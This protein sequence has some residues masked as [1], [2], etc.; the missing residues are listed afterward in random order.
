MAANPSST[1][2]PGTTPGGITL[3]STQGILGYSRHPCLY[4][5]LP[6]EEPDTTEYRSRYALVIIFTTPRLPTGSLH[7]CLNHT[8]LATH[9]PLPPLSAADYAQRARWASAQDTPPL[10]L[11]GP[12]D[13]LIVRLYTEL[14]AARARHH[15]REWTEFEYVLVNSLYYHNPH[16]NLFSTQQ[17]S[18]EDQQIHYCA[19]FNV[20]LYITERMRS[21]MNSLACDD[22][23]DS[24]DHFETALKTALPLMRL[25]AQLDLAFELFL[26]LKFMRA[27]TERYAMRHGQPPRPPVILIHPEPL[28]KGSCD[29]PHCDDGHCVPLGET[30]CTRSHCEDGDCDH[31]YCHD[32]CHSAHSDDCH[33]G[34]DVHADNDDDCHYGEDVIVVSDLSAE[35]IRALQHFIQIL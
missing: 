7:L 22:A 16:I 34:E 17:Q 13:P 12:V 28:P 29:R 5:P 19:G 20:P 23:L 24:K 3:S 4:C 35:Q 15:S 25:E 18:Q 1:Q 21:L 9:T 27:D 14:T 33:Y 2:P 11:L 8:I 30:I 6:D 31:E 10:T 26:S 32:D